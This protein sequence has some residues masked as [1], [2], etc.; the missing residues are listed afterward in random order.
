MFKISASEFGT[1]GI[2]R[3]MRACTDEF[4]AMVTE[5]VVHS[6]QK[7]VTWS[8]FSVT[9]QVELVDI[10]QLCHNFIYEPHTV[11]DGHWGVLPKP[12][13]VNYKCL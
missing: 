11:A 13:T 5:G 2:R 9:W 4:L 8:C 10:S 7:V 1:M 6:V 12:I 3:Q